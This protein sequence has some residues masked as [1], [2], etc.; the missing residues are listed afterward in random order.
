[1]V[2]VVDAHQAHGPDRLAMVERLI[3]QR[4]ISLAAKRRGNCSSAACA[5]A[6]VV[7]L[8]ALL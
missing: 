7:Q 2:L 8:G 4:I 3:A 6:S 1:M 5:S